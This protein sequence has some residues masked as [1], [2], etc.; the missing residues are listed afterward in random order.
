[1]QGRWLRL[2]AARDPVGGG[3][4]FGLVTPGRV[5]EAV[6]RN[7]VRRRLREICRLHR[8]LLAPGFL[9]VVVA[10][11]S[12]ARASFSEMREEWLILARRLS[13]LSG[14]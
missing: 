13:I 4:R 12:A 10:K 11:P 8:G 7:R 5:G 1:V 14:S 3:T 2:S 9:V 6:D